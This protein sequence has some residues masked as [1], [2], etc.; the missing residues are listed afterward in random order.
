MPKL[1][2]IRERESRRKVP[3]NGARSSEEKQQVFCSWQEG[4]GH[5]FSNSC[6]TLTSLHQSRLDLWG[7]ARG[8]AG[9]FL[10]VPPPPAAAADNG[11]SRLGFHGARPH[12]VGSLLDSSG[13]WLFDRDHR[14]FDH[15]YVRAQVEVLLVYWVLVNLLFVWRLFYRFLFQLVCMWWILVHYFRFLPLSLSLTDMWSI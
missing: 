11:H 6:Y 1:H 15:P 8:R 13:R 5:R 3:L 10:V 4:S 9:E 7:R 2:S 12:R 14:R